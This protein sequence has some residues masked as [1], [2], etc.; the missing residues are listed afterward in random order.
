MGGGRLPLAMFRGWK[1]K[2]PTDG[3]LS[4]KPANSFIVQ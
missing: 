4:G 1:N 3:I 2:D